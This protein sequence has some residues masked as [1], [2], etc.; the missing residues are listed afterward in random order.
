MDTNIA[1]SM[2][3]KEMID[4]GIKNAMLEKDNKKRDVLRVIKAEISREEAGI[5]VYGDDEVIKLIQ[6]SIK[7]LE[8]IGSP[9]AMDEIKI[10][11]QYIPKQM[12]EAEIE[13]AI[14]LL[15]IE[16][17]ASGVKDIGKLMNAFNS[18]Y[19]GMANGKLVSEVIKKIL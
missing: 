13:E 14:K 4:K 5:K 2:S 7:N 18:Q 3:L 15:V 11:E 8:I 19:K 10:L 12:S 1:D 6:K 17:G 16:T 9:E